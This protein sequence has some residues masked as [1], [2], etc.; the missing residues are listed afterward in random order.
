MIKRISSMVE[1]TTLIS[2]EAHIFIYLYTYIISR[3][4][5]YNVSKQA[6]YRDNSSS[7]CSDGMNDHMYNHILSS[8]Y[9]YLRRHTPL[10]CTFSCIILD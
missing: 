10:R 4:K 1:N 5:E 7:I 3:E 9:I 2:I 8:K 6:I